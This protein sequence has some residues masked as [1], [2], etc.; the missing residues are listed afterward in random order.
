MSIYSFTST[1]PLYLAIETTNLQNLSNLICL[2]RERASESEALQNPT[3][4]PLLI[5]TKSV[6]SS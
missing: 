4:N 1:R 3:I 2:N 5:D 6:A